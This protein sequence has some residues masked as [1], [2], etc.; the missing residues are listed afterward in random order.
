LNFLFVNHIAAKDTLQILIMFANS[1][2]II[3]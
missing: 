3:V 2:L 1:V